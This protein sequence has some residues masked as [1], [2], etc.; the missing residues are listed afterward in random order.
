MRGLFLLGLL[1]LVGCSGGDGVRVDAGGASFPEPIIQEWAKEF[2]AQT[3]HKIDYVKVGS[4]NGI[5]STTNGEYVFGC[6]DAP[7]DEKE[8]AVAQEKGGAMI[9]VPIIM[10]SVAI[11][12]NVAGVDDLKLSGP[13]LADI[14]MKRITRW[15]D[16]RIQ[17]LNEGLALPGENIIPLMRAESS[18]TTSIFSDYLSK[19]SPEFAAKVG[20]GKMMKLDAP[21]KKGNDGIADSVKNDPGTIGY[22]ELAYAVQ[23]GASMVQL[24]NKAGKF[25]KPTAEAV[26]AAATAAMKDEKSGKPYSLHDLTYSLTNAGG[27]ESYPIVG[28]S[29][30][31]LYNKRP[32]KEGKVA[33]EFLKW[34]VTEGQKDAEKLHYSPLPEA[35]RQECVAKLDS[36]T[37]E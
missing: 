9:H 21:G 8:M 14:Y 35:L 10:G 34:A 36:V 30:A 3:Q 2:R 5:T 11:I 28:M 17:S 20:A 37:F 16:P 32:A 15:N 27:E 31:I 4:G 22:V 12:Y 33:V 18:G 25:V 6:T 29:Y 26:T 24:Q 19:V 13:V 1:T 23:S 7:M